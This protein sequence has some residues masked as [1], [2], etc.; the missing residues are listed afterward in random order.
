MTGTKERPKKYSW[1]GKAIRKAGMMLMGIFLPLF[2]QG[3]DLEIQAIILSPGLGEIQVAQ[4]ETVAFS[5]TAMGGIPFSDGDETTYG[6]SWNTD[7]NPQTAS[8]VEGAADSSVDVT[9]ES[10][11]TFTASLTV[12]DSQGNKD[13]ASVRVVVSSG[14]D[15]GQPL[16]AIILSPSTTLPIRVVVG[17]TIRFE[18]IGA[19]G[20]PF[21]TGGDSADEPYGYFWDMPGI[22]DAVVA[23]NLRDVD[24]TFSSTGV[25]DLFFT[26]KDSRGVVD[27]AVINVT[28]VSG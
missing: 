1:G 19:G 7:K 26:I 2:L 23:D 27:T 11:G 5:G 13:T 18:G 24:V 21:F 4:G 3:C 8:S 17:R 22:K 10:V 15:S 16:R 14:V 20:I 9:F 6:F 25:F 28:V 12:S